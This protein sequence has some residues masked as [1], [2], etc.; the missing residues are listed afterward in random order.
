MPGSVVT[1]SSENFRLEL[2]P[3]GAAMTGLELIGADG[4]RR[5]LIHSRPDPWASD[6]YYRG[7][8]IGRF[9][10][11]INAAGFELDGQLVQLVANEGANQLH[12]GPGGFSER[13]WTVRERT[14]NEVTFE[15]VSQAGDQGF[16]G[17]LAVSARYSLIPGGAE[18]VYSA[19]TDEPTVVSLT[20]HPYFS[21][22]ETSIDS[23]RLTLNSVEFTA[24]RP[25]LVPTGELGSVV[26]TGLDF[27]S[28]RLLGEAMAAA[29]A[30]GTAI[31]GG[32]DHNFVVAGSGL[33][34]HARLTAPDGLHLRVVSDA[35]AIQIC[36]GEELGRVGLA[37]E[38]QNYPDA[39]NQA[40]FPSA[41]LRPGEVYTNTIRWLVSA[42]G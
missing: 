31:G 1:L 9:A 7:A 42:S 13:V 27:R 32:L 16:P 41:V 34:E 35:P 18:V 3:F 21:L 29:Q 20:S 38:P 14:G 24:V 4:A 36:S 26:G 30:D 23:L 8:S 5:Q 6:R 10:N 11:R 33:R 37:M 2:C 39:P 15:L 19:T 40:H 22:G 17:R 25:D 12:G 28:G